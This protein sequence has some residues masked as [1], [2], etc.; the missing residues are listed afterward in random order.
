MTGMTHYQVNKHTHS[1]DGIIS[2]S[3]TT[4]TQVMLTVF[5]T[6]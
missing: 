5:T 6:T 3:V 2:A 1:I 4:M